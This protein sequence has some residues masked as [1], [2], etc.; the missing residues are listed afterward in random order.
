MKDAT[1]A[2]DAFRAA[3]QEL[4]LDAKG[5]PFC[6]VVNVCRILRNHPEWS[7]RLWFDSF[8]QRLRTDWDG[9]GARNWRDDDGVA[10]TCWIQERQRMNR[11]S[12]AVVEQAVLLV[13]MENCRSEVLD[14]LRCLS[15]DGEARLDQLSVRGFGADD[16]DYAIAVG[17]NFVKGMVARAEKP[18]RKVDTALILEGPQGIGKTRALQALG[19][20]WYGSL[21]SQ[22]GTTDALLEMRGKWV[23]ELP[24][25]EAL[26]KR[27]VEGIKAFISRDTDTF[28]T[29]YGRHPADVPRSCLFAGTTN[30]STYLRDSTGARRFWPLRCGRIDVDWIKAN[31]TQLI[32]EALFRVRAGESWWELPEAEAA[33]EQ[34]LRFEGDPWADRVETYLIGRDTVTI[35]DILSDGLKVEVS[36]QDKRMQ[37]RVAHILRRLN[38]QRDQIGASRRRIWQREHVEGGAGGSPVVLLK[39][40]APQGSALPEPPEPL[41]IKD[42]V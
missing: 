21:H 35:A 40:P 12:L 18:G 28:R 17:S 37:M 9:C 3:M 7:G 24:E 26:S 31:R 19:G 6:N 38:W 4:E 20:P 14:W 8:H 22:F 33:R 42:Q 36:H 10:L 30:E 39:R 27:E 32:A 16:T 41:S 13:G 5:L 23:I 25:L 11:V 29:P 34:E 1:P 15:W 2:G